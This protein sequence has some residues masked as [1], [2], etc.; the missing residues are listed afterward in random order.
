MR[1]SVPRRSVLFLAAWPI[2]SKANGRFEESRLVGP[3][4]SLAGTRLQI[5]SFLDAIER[6]LD[7]EILSSLGTQLTAELESRNVTVRLVRLKDTEIGR[8]F[9]QAPAGNHIPTREVIVADSIE[10]LRFGAQYRLAILPMATRPGPATMYQTMWNLAYAQRG[11]AI[12]Q[13]TTIR[14]N[15]RAVPANQ[16][17]QGIVSD[18]VRSLEAAR[19]V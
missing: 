13:G 2:I 19:L 16:R 7:D 9:L 10:E 15:D 11:G 17:A 8:K 1:T 5:Y 3:S 14:L 6:F 4:V 18:F 12:W